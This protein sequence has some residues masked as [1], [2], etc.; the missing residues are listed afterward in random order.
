MNYKILNEADSFAAWLRQMPAEQHAE[1]MKF[2]DNRFEPLFIDRILY[3]YKCMGRGANNQQR[4]P[5]VLAV[6]RV[7]N[8][9]YTLDQGFLVVLLNETTNEKQVLTGVPAKVFGFNVFA[10]VPT[11]FTIRFNQILWDDGRTQFDTSAGMYVKTSNKSSFYS[12]RNHYFEPPKKM[13]ALYPDQEWR[14]DRS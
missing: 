9:S 7:I 6:V 12:Y 5:E 4:P 8:F 13:Q 10:S 1:Y 11:S 3:L 2:G 14:P